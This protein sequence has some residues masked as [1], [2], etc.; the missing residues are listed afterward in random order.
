MGLKLRSYA[1][2]HRAE[3]NRDLIEHGIIQGF[4]APLQGPAPCRV[5][6]VAE[7]QVV[8]IADACGFSGA[9]RAAGIRFG[10]C[11][12]RLNGLSAAGALGDR[13]YLR[14]VVSGNLIE[15]FESMPLE[16]TSIEKPELSVSELRKFIGD[17]FGCSKLDHIAPFAEWYQKKY[18]DYA[19]IEASYAY[20]LDRKPAHA[21]V[22]ECLKELPKNWGMVDCWQMIIDRP[23][24]AGRRS[25]VLPG[26]FSANFPFGLE[27]LN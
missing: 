18:G 5:E 27:L 9:A 25:L 8:S 7:G 16:L 23:E 21:E 17:L 6:L 12:F 3:I 14:C 10:W 19:F 1:P 11:G 22:I 20:L 13:V 26:I 15:E 24:Y 2:V 4:A